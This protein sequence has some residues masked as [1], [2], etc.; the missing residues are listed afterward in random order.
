MEYNI[1]TIDATGQLIAAVRARVPRNG[2][3]QS[4]RSSLDKVWAFLR[5]RPG[6]RTDGH[7]LFLYHHEPAGSAFVT[8]D[9]G[10]QVVKWFEQ[11][12]EVRCIETPRGEVVS[13]YH[14]GPYDGLSRAHAAIHD[15]CRKSERRIG[16]FSW[17]IYGDWTD[18]PNKLET[19]I[20][21]LLQP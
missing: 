21:Y 15:W 17:E 6:L 10:V 3:A 19:T 7:N 13:T 20:V 9:F 18:D 16:G 12:A 8:V 5:T 1:E 11:E 14:F 4:F 2:V